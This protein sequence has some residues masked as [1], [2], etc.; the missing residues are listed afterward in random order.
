[1]SDMFLLGVGR[2]F[3][4]SLYTEDPHVAAFA[5]V[6]LVFSIANQIS[7][8]TQTMQAFILRGFKDSATIFKST[9]LSFYVI[10]LPVGFLLCYEYLPSPFNGAKGFWVGIFLGLTFASL[11]YR[12]RVLFHWRALKAGL[13][14]F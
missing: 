6:L 4:T 7:E 10:A 11:Y 1:M 5:A 2:E 3:F 12:R 8:N 14:N 9:V 13:K